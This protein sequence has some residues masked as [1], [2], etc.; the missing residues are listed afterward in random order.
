MIRAIIWVGA[1]LPTIIALLFCHNESSAGLATALAILQ[2]P[3]LIVAALIELFVLKKRGQPVVSRGS[4]TGKKMAGVLAIILV[5][6]VLFRIY[7][8]TTRPSQRFHSDRIGP[9]AHDAPARL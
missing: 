2:G 8:A 3:V 4:I 6:C 7:A 1:F 9:A 5:V